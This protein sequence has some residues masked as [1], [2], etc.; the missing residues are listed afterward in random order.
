MDGGPLVQ[1]LVRLAR[2][3]WGRP[4]LVLLGA[5]LATLGSLTYL[6]DLKVDASF[7]GILDDGDPVAER[8]VDYSTRFGAASGVVLVIEGG[9]ET[10]RREVATAVSEALLQHLAQA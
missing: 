10:E 1:L 5:L 2:V 9:T 8:L 3:A 4:R 7:M 6:H